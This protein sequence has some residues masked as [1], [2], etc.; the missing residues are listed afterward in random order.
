M[1]LPFD[2]LLIGLYR[3]NQLY[4]SLKTLCHIYVYVN[5]KLYVYT[6]LYISIVNLILYNIIMYILYISTC[7]FII[8]LICSHVEL[9]GWSNYI[10]V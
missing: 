7:M 8:C 4:I 1:N 10:C 5:T 6:K 3:V 9:I 2:P